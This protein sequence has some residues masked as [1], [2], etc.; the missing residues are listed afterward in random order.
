MKFYSKEEY[1]EVGSLFKFSMNYTPAPGL[2]ELFTKHGMK[3]NSE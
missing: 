1:T 2:E 3:G